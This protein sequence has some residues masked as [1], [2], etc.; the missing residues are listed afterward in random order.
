V[1]LALPNENSAIRCLTAITRALNHLA[2]FRRWLTESN[3][4]TGNTLPV[5]NCGSVHAVARHTSLKE[6]EHYSA[7]ARR[8]RLAT[9]RLRLRRPLLCS[10][11]GF[12]P[13]SRR[14]S[15]GYLG[16]CQFRSHYQA[17]VLSGAIEPDAKAI[18]RLKYARRATRQL[19]RAIEAH[20]AR[21]MKREIWW[22]ANLVREE[23]T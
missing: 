13:T 12:Q 23:Q 4:V 18:E 14:A 9:S 19:G 16:G 21:L 7:K 8:K 15:R 5:E 11:N 1:V 10:S 17:L 6:I 22:R 20:I 2:F 3:L